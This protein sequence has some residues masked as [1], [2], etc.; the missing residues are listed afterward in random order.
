MTGCA[1]RISA[2]RTALRAPRHRRASGV[3]A[4]SL[5]LGVGGC[6]VTNPGPVQDEFLNASGSHAALVRGAER[7]VMDAL[8]RHAYSGI[9]ATTREVFPGGD[10]NSMLPLVQAGR[11]PQGSGDWNNLMQARFIAEDA[12]RRFA[13]PGVAPQPR[14]VAQAH[15]WAGY[16]LRILG[17]NYCEVVIDGGPLE[18][19][20][21][22]LTR[23]EQHFTNA[24]AVA[25]TD[26]LRTAAYAGRAQI[27]L[28]LSNW[29][30]AAS[31]AAQVPIDW[32]LQV[33]P[34]PNQEPARNWAGFYNDNTP[35]RVFTMKHTFFE[36]YYPATGDP[37]VPWRS[38]AA[39]PFSGAR[40]TGYTQTPD[41][42]VPWMQLMEEGGGTHYNP[43]TR[44][45]LA[46]G[47]EMLLIRAEAILV[48]TPANWASA[49]ALINQARTHYVS[50]TTG[51]PLVAYTATSAVE[52]WTHL[53]TER[54]IDGFLQGK[55][56]HDIRRWTR[57]NT[58]GELW[59]P[60]WRP[61]SSIFQ[62]QSPFSEQGICFV[63][64]NNERLANPNIP[65]DLVG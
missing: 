1:G 20:S 27:R 17:E 29:T 46:R 43:G 26:A 8:S 35:Y 58:P 50:L 28:A 52:T 12:L 2:G 36:D 11:L 56:L 3:L 62:A 48:Q 15:I 44:I 23:A 19:P 13:L 54:L 5:T 51:S 33:T 49:L 59:W 25:P 64:P 47:T 24:I 18:A 41:N 63:V 42:R 16:A 14:D 39:F 60:D 61:L 22:A 45:A 32:R 7:R 30:G 4:L 10:S 53:K 9:A 34:D 37:R 31:D 21:V 38:V 55:R 40:L 65:D 6:G 57:D